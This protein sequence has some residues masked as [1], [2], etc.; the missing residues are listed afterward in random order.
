MDERAESGRNSPHS[1]ASAARHGSSK[2]QPQEP[3]VPGTLEHSATHAHS[4]YAQQALTGLLLS[5]AESFAQRN[6]YE[7]HPQVVFSQLNVNP[8]LHVAQ[9]STMRHLLIPALGGFAFPGGMSGSVSASQPAPHIHPQNHAPGYAGGSHA[10]VPRE[11]PPMADIAGASSRSQVPSV[12]LTGENSQQGEHLCGSQSQGNSANNSSRVAKDQASHGNHSM[13]HHNN[14]SSVSRSIAPAHLNMLHL[15]VPAAAA[16]AANNSNH[17]AYSLP[18]ST[19]YSYTQQLQAA[20]NLLLHATSVISP[21]TPSLF[22]NVVAPNLSSMFMQPV[23]TSAPD[24]LIGTSC[25]GNHNPEPARRSAAAGSVHNFPHDQ[26]EQNEENKGQDSRAAEGQICSTGSQ[27]YDPG[28]VSECSGPPAS[29]TQRRGIDNG[30]TSMQSLHLQ[31][32]DTAHPAASVHATVVAE[33]QSELETDTSSMQQAD[34]NGA[35]TATENEYISQT[36]AASLSAPAAATATG[37]LSSPRSRLSSPREP[38]GAGDSSIAVAILPRSTVSGA[39]SGG[40]TCS[41]TVDMSFHNAGGEGDHFESDTEPDLPDTTN[42]RDG[43]VDGDPPAACTLSHFRA[44]AEAAQGN[45]PH[46]DGEAP[47]DG[48]GP[49]PNMSFSGTHDVPLYTRSVHM[50]HGSA[51]HGRHHLNGGSSPP[52]RNAA[53][54]AAVSCLAPERSPSVQEDIAS[55]EGVGQQ[56][57]ASPMWQAEYSASNLERGAGEEVSPSRSRHMPKHSRNGLCIGGG[58]RLSKHDRSGG[59]MSA[60]END[61]PAADGGD[62]A[63]SAL[64]TARAAHSATDVWNQLH[65]MEGTNLTTMGA[66]MLLPPASTLTTASQPSALC[67]Q[68]AVDTVSALERLPQD[69][70]VHGLYGTLA[71]T[72][73]AAQMQANLSLAAPST[74]DVLPQDTEVHGLYGQLAATAAAAQMTGSN[75]RNFM[76]TPGWH[77]SCFAPPNGSPC[78]TARASRHHHTSGFRPAH[79]SSQPHHHRGGAH[80]GRDN[81]S[82]MNSHMNGHVAHDENDTDHHSMNSG[83]LHMQQAESHPAQHADSHPP[84]TPP[85]GELVGEQHGEHAA[86]M[87]STHSVRMGSKGVLSNQGQAHHEEPQLTVVMEHDGGGGHSGQN[88]KASA[89]AGSQYAGQE[90]NDQGNDDGT[91]ADDEMDGPACSWQGDSGVTSPARNAAGPSRRRRDAKR[92][93]VSH[94]NDHVASKPSSTSM[95]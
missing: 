66:V 72:A 16:A 31:H 76:H 59:C 34:P 74:S 68:P 80:P 1:P 67:Q 39:V 48:A 2:V 8:S 87:N 11:L 19:H 60:G 43:H 84:N 85:Y 89:A 30:T 92:Q 53:H 23:A 18:A 81:H 57:R 63:A 7:A 10:F 15:P 40:A 55:P 95:T 88:H 3:N 26:D 33:D 75:G 38:Q 47:S 94:N 46:D 37:A 4:T 49:A 42:S 90:F 12:H 58:A 56:G 82:H 50:P 91:N 52:H 65:A 25:A 61:G 22:P 41:G 71:A 36:R 54:S 5:G 64:Q 21:H 78:R 70:E 83:G 28:G 35:H 24:P 44:M 32:Q 14:Q 45:D 9:P 27:E 20:V 86:R 73:A 17:L 51:I 69:T 79:S 13:R 62:M 6:L 29:L 77:A 93:R